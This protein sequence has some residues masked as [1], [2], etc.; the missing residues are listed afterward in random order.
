MPSQLGQPTEDNCKSASEGL[1]EMFDAI[2]KARRANYLGHLNE[3]GL[4]IS[5]ANAAGELLNACR[6][7]FLEHGGGEQSPFVERIDRLVPQP[8]PESVDTAALEV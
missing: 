1:S 8:A 6:M 4:L 3:I 2:P 7:Y 5:G